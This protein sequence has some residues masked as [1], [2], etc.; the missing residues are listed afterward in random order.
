MKKKQV[1]GLALGSGSARGWSH[2]GIIRALG[3]RG[4]VPDIVCG[5]S[6]GAVIGGA[7]A[8]GYLDDLEEWGRSLA[9]KD[10]VSFFDISVMS[11]GVI[12]GKRLMDFLGGHMGDPRIE[13]LPVRFAAVA[14]DLDTGREMW[15]TSGPLLEAV[16]ASMALPGF[17][18]PLKIGDRWYVD[19]GLVNPV[20]VSL[21]RAMGADTVIAVNLNSSMVG[22]WNQPSRRG[23]ASTDVQDEHTNESLSDLAERIRKKFAKSLETVMAQIWQGDSHRPG[24]FDVLATSIDIMQDRIT[25]SRMAGDPPDLILSP[26]LEHLGLLEYYRAAEGIEEGRNCVHR[27]EHAVS[28]LFR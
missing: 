1:V 9:L 4:I 6:A 13:A 7:Y 12:A 8:A 28:Q 2:I 11:G 16:R 14:T 22:K 19:G 17:L 20:P 27:A 10:V 25:R 3:E 21:C 18:A 23:S 5:C 15:F 26:R 24:L